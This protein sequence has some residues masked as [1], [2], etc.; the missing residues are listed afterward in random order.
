M[1]T[2]AATGRDTAHIDLAL[3]DLA[4]GETLALTAGPE[5]AAVILSGTVEA[6]AGDV[7]LGRAGGRSS[8]FEGPGYAVY[9]PPAMALTL[10]AVD[11]PAQVVIT[12]APAD[13]EGA[14]PPRIIRPEDQRIAEVGEGNWSRTVRTMIGPEHPANR[15][16]VGETINPPGNWSSYPP[17]RHDRH[18]PPREAEL[19]EVYFF[20]VDPPGGFGI[21]V[22]YEED[23]A[24]ES[25]LVGDD[26]IAAIRSG[27]H[28]VV[29]ASGYTLYYLWVLAGR[30]REMMPYM[31]P[32]HAWVQ[33]G[34]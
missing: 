4:D 24:E 13:A 5:R 20:R 26:D 17:H 9:G 11:G 8:V 34:A 33:E 31:D 25:F 22:R 15:L 21:Q 27:F 30:G 19:E 23:G 29:A 10:Q 12:A 28:P 2:L 18:D 14:P 7:A 1:R 16:L 32:R 3:A 6:T